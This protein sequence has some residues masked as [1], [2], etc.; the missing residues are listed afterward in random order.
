L[1]EN[2]AIFFKVSAAGSNLRQSGQRAEIKEGDPTRIRF[3]I[4]IL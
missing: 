4:L 2:P 3:L 1:G